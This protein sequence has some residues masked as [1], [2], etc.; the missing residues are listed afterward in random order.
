MAQDHVAVR[1]TITGSSKVWD[2]AGGVIAKTHAVDQVMGIG[3][4]GVR[5]DAPKVRLGVTVLEAA[6]ACSKL[7][8]HVVARYRS[9][10]V[11]SCRTVET[12]S[13][14]L[15][16]SGAAPHG[17]LHRPDCNGFPHVE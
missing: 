13:A 11:S 17:K 14:Q 10:L 1:V 15:Y 12:Q 2:G 8:M 9:V 16:M 5:V 3:Q 6:F 7:L 4:I